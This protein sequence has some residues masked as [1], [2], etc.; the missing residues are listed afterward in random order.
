MPPGPAWRGGHTITLA[1]FVQ[2]LT[3]NVAHFTQTLTSAENALARDLARRGGWASGNANNRPFNA[4]ITFEHGGGSSQSINLSDPGAYLLSEKD[5]DNYRNVRPSSVSL[6][7]CAQALQLCEG[8]ELPGVASGRSP[9]AA[10]HD[11]G[12]V[13]QSHSEH[14]HHQQGHRRALARLLYS[15]AAGKW[16]HQRFHAYA[17]PEQ[18]FLLHQ[19]SGQAGWKHPGDGSSDTSVC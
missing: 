11:L 6:Q 19:L 7:C 2:P 3:V 14:S 10:E 17:G 8:N 13:R 4:S 1:D 15:K 9:G 18:D 5:A 12:Q 16:R